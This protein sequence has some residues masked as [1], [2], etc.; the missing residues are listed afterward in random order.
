MIGDAAHRIHP[1]AGQGVNLGWHDVQVLK[2]VLEKASSNGSDLG[3]YNIRS[4]SK[5]FSG[6]LT[7]LSEYDSAAQRHNVPVMVCVDWLNRLYRTD[8][9][10]LV[11]LRSYGLA[12]VNRLTPIKDFLIRQL[13]VTK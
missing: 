7:Y 3:L 8:A 6:S 12:A 4:K 10:P 5:T 2:K 11:A 9:I 13:S 1:L